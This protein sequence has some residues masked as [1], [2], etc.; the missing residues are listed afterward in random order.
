MIQYVLFLLIL[1]YDGLFIYMPKTS[2][3]DLGCLMLNLEILCSLNQGCFHQ[4]K[5]VFI[6]FFWEPES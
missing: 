2:I 1:T 5:N 3:K 4:K 6:C